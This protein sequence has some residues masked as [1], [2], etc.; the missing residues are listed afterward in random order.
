M[1]PVERAPEPNGFEAN[2]R[3]KGLAWIESQRR[4]IS[5]FPNHWCWCEPHLHA[6][7]RG[8]CGWAAVWI[9]SGQVEHFIS[10]TACVDQG[11]PELAYDWNN[12]RY[13]MPE[14]NSKKSR[15]PSVLDPFD[16][17]PGWFEIVLPQLHLR[18][19]EQVPASHRE[20]ARTT[21]EFLGLTNGPKLMR[22]RRKYMQQYRDGKTRIALLDEDFP[23]LADAL[24]KLFAADEAELSE[25]LR[26][27]RT[28]VIADRLAADT[29]V[30]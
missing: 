2:V 21:L 22:L 10:Q 6:A 5:R 20:L 29:S 27:W 26:A 14:L 15:R 18:M 23:L 3:S 13:I 19:T 4:P 16:V 9:S 12:L 28:D 1:I 24:R 25:E 11:R 7:F 30:P 17:Q 8:R